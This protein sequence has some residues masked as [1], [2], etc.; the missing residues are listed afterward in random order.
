MIV[1]EAIQRV[2]TRN[3]LRRTQGQ[4]RRESPGQTET[5]KTRAA[6]MMTDR[7]NGGEVIRYAC[8]LD[9]EY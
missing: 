8:S 1:M 5:K 2:K 4:G 6:M 7:D 3:L 9:A